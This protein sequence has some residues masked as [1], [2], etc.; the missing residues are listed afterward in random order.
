MHEENEEKFLIQTQSQAKTS[1]TTLP[2][3]HGIRKKLDPNMKPERQH[4]LPKKEVTEKPHIGQG[5][6]GLRRKP[7]DLLHHSFFRSDRK[8]PGKIQN[9]NKENKQPTTYRR[10]T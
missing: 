7:E 4:A 9:R 2:E 10:H 3:V 8:N 6:A 1:G 5:R